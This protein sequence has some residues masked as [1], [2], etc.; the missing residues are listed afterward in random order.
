[1]DVFFEPTRGRPFG[2]ELGYFDTVA[3]IKEKI[4]KDQGIPVSKQILIF[5]GQV[6]RD[7]LNVHFSEILDRSRIQLVVSTDSEQLRTKSEETSAAAARKVQ[8][9]L[10]LPTS[11]LGVTLE[12]DASDTIRRLKER[13]HEMDGVPINR[14]VL[15]ED[16]NEL[17]DHRSLQDYD[18]S[19]RSEIEI[20]VRP[21]PTTS[22]STGSG[23]AASSKKLRVMVLT[24]CGTRKIAVEVNA[25]DNVGE[26]RKEL[27]KLSQRLNFHLPSDGYFFIYK[28]NVMDEDRSFR[29]H[30]VGQGDTLEIFSGSV[31]GGS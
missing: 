24:K 2:M 31:T 30:H 28:Q 11:K 26:L 25:S 6:L 10:K 22:S 1:M 15:R 3:E 7:D 17:H 21:S 23:N 5:N 27:Q 18:L 12:P 14:L 20:G 4:Q 29:W 16:G 13:I 19:D 8:L 9:R